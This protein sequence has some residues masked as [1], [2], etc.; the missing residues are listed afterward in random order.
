MLA[1]R[2]VVTPLLAVVLVALAEVLV[3]ESMLTAVL[4]ALT[5]AVAAPAVE[6]ETH[7]VVEAVL[8]Q[9]VSFGP[10]IHAH[11]HQLVQ[12]HLK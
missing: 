1:A 10:V 2:L 6:V 5:V 12:E 7:A 4:A 3:V 9:F 11:S 8:A